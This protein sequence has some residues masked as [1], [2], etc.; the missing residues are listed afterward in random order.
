MELI[1]DSGKAEACLARNY[2][3]F[4]H[5]RWED[6]QNDGCA[7]ESDATA[8]LAAG[9]SITDLVRATVLTA[10]FRNRRFD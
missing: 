3:R 6:T 8:A 9:G 7:L 1:A 4:T 2:F 10:E 5:A